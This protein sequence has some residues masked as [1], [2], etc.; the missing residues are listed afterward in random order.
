VG[1]AVP[2][3]WR[4]GLALTPRGEFSIIIASIAVGAG[5][6]PEI[7]PFAATYMMVTIIMGP[8]LARIPDMI[9]FKQRVRARQ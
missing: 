8:V 5:L 4:A 2:G 6:N 3:R 1:I 9:W 7:M